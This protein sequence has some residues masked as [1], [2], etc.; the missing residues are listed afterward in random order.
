MTR[1]FAFKLLAV[2]LLLASA[3]LDLDS[4]WPE[5]AND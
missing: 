2:S 3:A 4:D 5:D 1:L